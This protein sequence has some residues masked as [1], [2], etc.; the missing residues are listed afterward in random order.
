MCTL[1]TTRYT[2]ELSN[3][4][5]YAN[6]ETESK[7]LKFLSQISNVGQHM[8]KEQFFWAMAVSL[9][10]PV[11]PQNPLRPNNHSKLKNLQ[12]FRK[13]AARNFKLAPINASKFQREIVRI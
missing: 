12:K 7:F 4:Q 3:F 13:T 9:K 2:A 1:S 10:L 11:K 6:M 5:N 8:I